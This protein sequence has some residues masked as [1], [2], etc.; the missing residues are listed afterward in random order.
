MDF[1]ISQNGISS[2]VERN[3]YN[4]EVDGAAKGESGSLENIT[5]YGVQRSPSSVTLEG[6][7]SAAFNYEADKKV[8]S[9][10]LIAETHTCS[11][12]RVLL[13]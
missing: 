3:G 13:F 6:V 1:C 9:E 11:T 8:C 7:G 5:I 2:R 4:P 12:L 10:L